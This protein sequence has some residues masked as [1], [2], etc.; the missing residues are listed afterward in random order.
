MIPP[1]DA[2]SVSVLDPT[3]AVAEAT[4]ARS[5]ELPDVPGEVT[6]VTPGGNP[7]NVRLTRALNP[8]IAVSVRPTGVEVVPSATLTEGAENPIAK[9]GVGAVT[10]SE[11][12][13]V[14][15]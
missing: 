11:T 10:V 2:V 15:V 14:L 4:N 8:F 3:G 12:V 1:P 9:V 6:I 5:I 13:V 7:L